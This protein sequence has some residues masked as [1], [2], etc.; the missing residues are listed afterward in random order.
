[1]WQREV[2]GRKGLLVTAMRPGNELPELIYISFSTSSHHQSPLCLLC[3]SLREECNRYREEHLCQVPRLEEGAC[4]P[5]VRYDG[6]QGLGETQVTLHPL[7]TLLLQLHLRLSWKSL[8]HLPLRNHPRTSSPLPPP[9]SLNLLLSLSPQ[10][11]HSQ[12]PTTLLTASSSP[13]CPRTDLRPS[14]RSTA[15]RSVQCKMPYLEA[16]LHRILHSIFV[17][18]KVQNCAPQDAFLC[19]HSCLNPA[20]EN[21]VMKQPAGGFLPYVGQRLPDFMW[22][23]SI[24]QTQPESVATSMRRDQDKCSQQ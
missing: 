5:A 17:A 3:L 19:S 6:T 21:G 18:T 2:R 4:Y 1:M 12:P 24:I 20:S 7:E 13:L 9:V 22:D 14:H 10:S 8:T 11:S 23:A 15:S 16:S